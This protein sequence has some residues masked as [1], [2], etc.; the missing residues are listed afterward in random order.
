MTHFVVDL[1]KEYVLDAHSAHSLTVIRFADKLAHYADK[2]I[3]ME[4]AWVVIMA[5]NLKKENVLF[6]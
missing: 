6:C 2:L 4:I 5:M 3:L 1:K